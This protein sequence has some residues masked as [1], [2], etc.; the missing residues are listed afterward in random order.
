MFY[1]V[2][3]WVDPSFTYSKWDL[4]IF[5]TPDIHPKVI[6]SQ[7]VKIVPPHCKQPSS[8]GGWPKYIEINKANR[9]WRYYVWNIQFCNILLPLL[10]SYQNLLY[11]FA[12][13]IRIFPVGVRKLLPAEVKPPVKPS[14]DKGRWLVLHGVLID[15]IN[16]RDNHCCWVMWYP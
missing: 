11:W 10:Q 15:D 16:H 8:H 13:Q 1:L 5:P 12:A 9:Y 3:T 4:Q 7:P 2:M 6:F 14:S